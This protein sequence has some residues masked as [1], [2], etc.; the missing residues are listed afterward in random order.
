MKAKEN[1][2]KP[3][4]KKRIVG[5]RMVKEKDISLQE[6][7]WVEH[8]KTRFQGAKRKCL[9]VMT[10]RTDAPKICPLNYECFHCGYDQMM[11]EYE[12]AAACCN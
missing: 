11:D 2:M 8:L 1:Q 5:F 7:G 9:H 10:G 6:P 12:L 4:K 3:S